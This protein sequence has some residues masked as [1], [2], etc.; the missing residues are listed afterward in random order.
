MKEKPCTNQTLRKSEKLKKKKQKRN[1]NGI[2][3][4]SMLILPV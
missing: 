3:A 2:K 4:K 1:K